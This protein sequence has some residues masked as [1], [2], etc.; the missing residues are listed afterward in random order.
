MLHDAPLWVLILLAI[1]MWLIW[2]ITRALEH[3][4]GAASVIRNDHTTTIGS[5]REPAPSSAEVD[6]A[7]P[8][9]A[10][11]DRAP[12]APAVRELWAP[13]DERH[14]VAGRP[15]AGR[16]AGRAA[17]S[18]E[19][20]AEPQLLPVVQEE[21]QPVIGREARGRDQQRG[22]EDAPAPRGRHE[23]VVIGGGWWCYKC[24]VG[25]V[26]GLNPVGGGVGAALH[27]D[28]WHR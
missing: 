8:E 16:S 18:G 19:H 27:N 11:A 3:Q 22:P 21:V 1:A 20:R 24:N 9:A 4:E 23:A 25:V 14:E 28:W 5:S 7:Q 26:E 17:D 10:Q 12:A 2:A 15:P 6:D 13:G